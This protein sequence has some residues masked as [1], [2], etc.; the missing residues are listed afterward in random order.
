MLPDK[1]M[2]ALIDPIS[3]GYSASRMCLIGMNVIAALAAIWMLV[4]GKDPTTLVAAVAGSDA[5]VYGLNS[6]FKRG[7]PP[8]GSGPSTSSGE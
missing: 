5:T 4:V 7:M 2:Y 1:I 6:A 8:C 3:G